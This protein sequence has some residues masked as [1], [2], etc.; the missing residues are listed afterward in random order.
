MQ[1]INKGEPIVLVS[2]DLA[3]GLENVAAQVK[4]DISA[5]N[6]TVSVNPSDSNMSVSGSAV[7]YSDVDPETI[8]VITAAAYEYLGKPFRVKSVRMFSDREDTPWI[9]M[10]RF[11]S[12]V[13]SQNFS[14]R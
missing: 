14:H 5:N 8:A 7:D 12:L 4:V 13:S 6:I 9:R 10:G 1:K 2:I 3:N 11:N